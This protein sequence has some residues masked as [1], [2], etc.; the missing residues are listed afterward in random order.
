MNPQPPVVNYNQTRVLWTDE[1]IFYL[2][3]QRLTRNAEYWE[4]SKR[5]HPP[6]WHSIADKVLFLMNKNYI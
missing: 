4:L 6:F 5:D 3:D 2:I 1:E